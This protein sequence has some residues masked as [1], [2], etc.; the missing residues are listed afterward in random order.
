[1]NETFFFSFA[2]LIGRDKDVSSSALNC[3][4][5]DKS[6]RGLRRLFWAKG[7]GGD[8]IIT[9]VVERAQQ[10]ND[11]NE[12]RKQKLFE[13]GVSSCEREERSADVTKHT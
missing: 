10:R 5:G 9:L 4:E 8:A 3:T 12:N 7:S 2:H 11:K 13:I 6:R 1:L